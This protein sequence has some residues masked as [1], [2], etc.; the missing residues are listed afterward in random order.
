MSKEMPSWLKV[1]ILV[2]TLILL[3][4]GLYGALCGGFVAPHE[5]RLPFAGIR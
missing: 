1:T 5:C 4:A 3:S 2:V